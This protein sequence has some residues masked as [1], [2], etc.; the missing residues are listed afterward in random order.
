MQIYVDAKCMEP[1][2][3]DKIFREKI[4]ERNGLIK[5]LTGAIFDLATF[6]IAS[7]VKVLK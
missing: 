6:D 1:A 2:R 7:H 4:R 5:L 3:R